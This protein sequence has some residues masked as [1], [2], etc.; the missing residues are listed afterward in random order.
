MMPPGAGA[1]K[2]RILS[3]LSIF[4]LAGTHSFWEE[5]VNTGA[6]ALSTYPAVLKAAPWI[7]AIDLTTEPSVAVLIFA[8]FGVLVVNY[9]MSDRTIGG[10]HP[11]P[12]KKEFPQPSFKSQLESFVSALRQHL[13][14]TDR[15]SNWS[16]DYYTEL[17]AEV[18]IVPIGG[19]IS[20]KR[21][22]DLQTALR[23][24]KRTQA[25]LILGDPGGG[26]SVAL[27]KLAKDMLAEVSGTGRIP[28][29]INLREW[30]PN[31]SRRA[32][33]WT[34]T[35]PPTI[36]DL[37]TFVLENIKARGDVFTEE[38]VDIYFRD[39]W[40]H[41]RLF[42]IFDSFDE[43]PELLDVN[44]ESWLIECLSGLLSRFIA[45]NVNGRGVVA[46]RVF[47]RPT[48]A[49]LA[50]KILD[51]RP[52]SEERIMLALARYPA[53]TREI[54]NQLF[55]DRHDLVP[56]ARNPFLM[57]LL[58]EW[59]STHRILPATQADLYDNYLRRRLNKV[60]QRIGKYNLSVDDILNTATQIAE[61]V[62]D[63]P[64]YGLEAPVSVL[65][66]E[67]SITHA[68]EA[69]D[70]LSHA[71]IARVTS[72][73]AISF[74]FVHRRF[75]E[76][77]VTTRLLAAPEKLPLDHI[78]TDSRG[79]DAM[80]LYAQLCD[81]ATAERLAM[82]CWEEICAHLENPPTRLRA[83]HSLR[84]L[85]D[86]FRSRRGAVASFAEAL[87]AFIQVRATGCD[88]LIQAKICLEATGL[89]KD[90]AAVPILQS[91]I[92]GKNAWLRETA[93]RACRHLPKISLNLR[94]IVDDYIINMPIRQFW[95]NRRALIFSLALSDALKETHR[96][97]I[98]R[99][100]NMIASVAAL[101]VGIVIAPAVAIMTVIWIFSMLSLDH[102][103]Y[104]AYENIRSGTGIKN[105]R[106][107]T[108]RIA[109]GTFLRMGQ[110]VFGFL[111][112]ASG[113]IESTS[114]GSKFTVK[115][116][117]IGKVAF[118]HQ[119]ASSAAAC[120]AIAAAVF[121]FD[122]LW[123]MSAR[124]PLRN[125]LLSSWKQRVRIIFFSFTCILTVPIVFVCLDWISNHLP[126]WLENIVGISISIA[127]GIAIIL[128]FFLQARAYFR[129]WLAF[130][131]INVAGRMSRAEIA[132]A[133][134]ALQSPNF[135]LA[136]VRR[137]AELK[138][139]A[140]GQWPDH[141]K[142]STNGDSA[143]TELAKL[144]ERWLKIDR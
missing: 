90:N 135:R 68:N 3:L 33:E 127:I 110:H 56:L 42:F 107:I 103:I 20:K 93:F 21:I 8:G 50:K 58:G 98:W 75:L 111:L 144:E 138:T 133:L 72:G 105:Y 141:F 77:L 128:S 126:A 74:A 5:L 102:F 95:N 40:Q 15:Q 29:Y 87:A 113:I 83:I 6:K 37:E 60:E 142:L 70:V 9:F 65:K 122:W 19:A 115:D 14:T 59:V 38:F 80:V 18:E 30:L 17:E 100:R 35:E 46:S 16:P 139:V 97:A 11:I 48:Q 108:K 112:L 137:L 41:G 67:H 89:L 129:D 57:A 76:Y 91:A 131:K 73:D 24:D 86:A 99:K 32:N 64:S 96:I 101:S 44:E 79:R 13:E 85:T 47:R 26:K 140:T 62:F 39:L 34:E 132:D 94:H 119:P 27:R 136:V 78:P 125:F 54:Q 31:G 81:D 49:F 104:P 23:S 118:E 12:L 69:I 134:E 114:F 82:L 66:H 109:E 116:K 52:M 61:F 55:R 45:T 22:V 124:T 143:I 10:E 1:T 120:L 106:L 71:R 63:S 117:T 2:V 92:S 123:I 4:A 36:H 28:L 130:K 7:A 43:I 88:D 84:F 51:I 25:F 121:S 53:F